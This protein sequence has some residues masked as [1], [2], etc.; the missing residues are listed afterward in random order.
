MTQKRDPDSMLIRKLAVLKP[1]DERNPLKTVK[2][3][4][5]FLKKAH[6]IRVTET[7]KRRPIGWMQSIQSDF[8]SHRKERNP[9]LGTLGTIML[10]VALIF[11]G[12]GITVA[13]AQTSQPDQLLYNVK[14][15]SEN[16]LLDLTSNPESQF[17]LALEYETRRAEEIQTML[18]AGEVPS[19]EVRTRYQTQIEQAIRLALNLSDDQVIKAF[20]QIQ[21]RL[22]TQQETLAQLRL[23]SNANAEGALL[24]IRSMVQERIQ[25][26]E[27][28]ENNYLQLRDQLQLQNQLN[29]PDQG[30]STNPGSDTSP[31]TGSG[32]P[33]AEGTPT[34]GSGYGPGN[35]TG[36]CT[37]C[38]PSW[39]GFGGQL[40]P[41]PGGQGGK[42]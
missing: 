14:L 31:G 8:F 2:G 27:A 29:N 40:T 13:A 39:N 22:Q 1:T 5:A 41:I 35:G 26:L 11:G 34:P 10:I 3:R 19:E 18:L 24:Q 21:L 30:G 32:N 17:N 42:K 12:S 9:M 23:N 25:L 37:S 7:T 15:L 36:D 33:W 20:E 38:T 6:E 16:A 28:G 4:A